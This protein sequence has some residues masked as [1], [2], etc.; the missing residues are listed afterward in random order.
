MFA[1]IPRA[2]GEQVFA[3]EPMFIV[4]H[5]GNR[6]VATVCANCCA[7]VGPLQVQLEA[8][9]S[10]ARFT[11][12]LSS[13]SE[14][15]LHWQAEMASAGASALPTGVR[16][17]QGCGEVYCSETCREAHFNRCHN[18][19]CAG[20]VQSEDH[21]LIKFKYHAIEHADSL[22]LAAQVMACLVNRARACGGGPAVTQ[23]LMSELLG[24]CHAPFRDACRAP[25]G[26]GK[27]AEFLAYTDSLINEAA[28]LL[29]AA[30][31]LQAPAEAAAL[32]A[33]G[34]AFFA[35][36]M[37][38]FEY[39]NID[40]EV[41]SP[42]SQFFAAKGRALVSCMDN[43]VA[44]TEL[45]MLER[46][47]REKEWVMQCVWGEETTG[48]FAADGDMDGSGAEADSMMEEMDKLGDAQVAQ[49]AMAQ[50]RAQVEAMPFER[51][52][53]APWPAFHGSGLFIF[54]ARL[55]H[56]CQPNLKLHFPGNSACLTAVAL[57]PVAPGEEFCISYIRQDANAQTRRKQLL[58]WYGF[59]C[60][61]PRCAQE[62][63]VA[64]RRTQKR[65][66]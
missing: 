60:S 34:P 44:R 4:Q 49:S 50:A 13:L 52:L 39:N 59:S 43:P 55:N 32:F 38:L 24:F 15:L 5:T 10:E 17:T 14:A 27:D 29:K 19:L 16:C 26:R 66:K 23:G 8:L 54:V 9:F 18:L 42:I 30:L 20:L 3:D 12:V 53:E 65:L 1:S 41:A 6:R 35:E 40:V 2:M 48:N 37:G 58:E 25:A 28:A 47:L 63:S 45:G 7:F 62:D 51:L 36:V 56:S 61:C 31:D 57:A 22:L 21:P 11:P 64:A 33:S 46:L